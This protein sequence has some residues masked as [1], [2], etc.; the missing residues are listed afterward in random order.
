M[1]NDMALLIALAGVLELAALIRAVASNYASRTLDFSIETPRN[2]LDIVS[3]RVLV[4]WRPTCSFFRHK[5]SIV[6][7]AFSDPRHVRRE[8][9]Y[10]RKHNCKKHIYAKKRSVINMQRLV[11]QRILKRL[12]SH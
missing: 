7:D 11:I 12:A 5:Y 10:Q 8:H 4:G 3:K 2:L 1:A 6:G 9:K